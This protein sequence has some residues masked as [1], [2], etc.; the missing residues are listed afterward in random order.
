MFS[1]CGGCRYDFTAPDYR[2]KKLHQIEQWNLSDEPYWTSAGLR[3]RAD[4]G[5]ADGRFG[6]FERGTKN[7]IAVE[8]CPNLVPEINKILPKLA[9]LPWHGA[10]TAL[11]TLCDN[12]LDVA[13]NSVV[14]Y[15]TREFKESVQ[16]LDL[17]RVSWNG[18]IVYMTGTPKIR[19]GD[20]VVDYPIGAFLQPTVA[21]EAAMRKFV[22]ENANGAHHIADLFCGVGNFTFALGA[23]GHG[24]DGASKTSVD[25]FDIAGIGVKRDL[26][27]RPLTAKMLNTYDLVVMDPPRAGAEAQCRELA[28]SDVSRVIYV[29]CN[30]TTLYRDSKI[31]T[32]AGYKMTR[33]AAFDQ[34]V[35]TEHW[36][37]AIVFQK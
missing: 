36:E 3:R 25:G 24:R 20:F 14:P 23:D 16:R 28:C 18:N 21:S 19:F 9:K 12:G 32:A 11:V 33:I 31:L 37:L 6:F 7:I 1:I 27:K 29:S 2:T 10:G 34:F 35:G 30:P 8:N 26:F 15:F 17:L 13:I 5:F 22:L 4:F